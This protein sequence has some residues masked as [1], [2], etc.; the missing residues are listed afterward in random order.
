MEHA[1]RLVAASGRAGERVVVQVRTPEPALGRYY[2]RLLEELG[3]RTT[4]R[5]LSF[6]ESDLY[7]PNTRATT[8]PTGWAADYLAASDLHP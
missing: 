5:N 1:R 6:A 4:L 2:A 7:D 8:G 3:F